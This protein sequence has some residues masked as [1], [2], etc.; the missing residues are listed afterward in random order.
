MALAFIIDGG[1]NDPPGTG[2]ELYAAFPAV[3]EVYAEAAA[4]AG[5]PV[6][7]LL[8]WEL[9]RSA[10]HRQVGAIRQSALALGVCDVLA[11]RGVRPDVV[12]GLS[13]G[14]MVGAA[15]TGAVARRD[16][17]DMLAHLRGV[18]DASGPP[19][20][21]ASFFVPTGREPDE[22]A[23][24]FPDGVYVAAQMG[25]VGD[26]SVQLTLIS[27]HREA[28]HRLA[29]RLPD[30]SVL[31]IPPDITTAYHSPLQRHIADYVE[32]VLARMAF[33]DPRIPLC[34]GL[35]PFEY[36]T[37]EQVRSMFLRNHTESVSLPRLFECLDRHATALS[38]VIGPSMGDLFVTA[39]R[40]TIVRVE[41]P[42]H[43]P[44]ALEALHES[45]LAVRH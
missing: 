21:V 34:G 1:L 28:L 3:R 27:G 41:S 22:F 8:T 33:R 17:F 2:T 18:P 20:G 30:R 16:L 38:F 36:R 37:G 26:R 24:G 6:R 25:P 10:E 42:E 7:R 5:M 31:R 14:G 19:Q 4:C 43:V 35:A 40:H 13:L 45:G 12:A 39:A 9:E 11:E 23:G 32:P 15:V 44:E 29:E